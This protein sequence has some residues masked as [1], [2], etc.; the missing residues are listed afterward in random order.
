MRP[1]RIPI[2]EVVAVLWCLILA[3]PSQAAA[4]GRPDFSGTWKLNEELSDDPYEMMQTMEQRR[5]QGGMGG[6][7]GGMIPPSVG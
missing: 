6:G 1:K 2:A 7:G 5:A 4:S 3:L